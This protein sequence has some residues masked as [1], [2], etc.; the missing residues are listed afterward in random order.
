M[1][2]EGPFSPAAGAN[3]QDSAPVFSPPE[4][5][6]AGAHIASMAQYTEMY[7]RSIKDP[8]GF[9]GDMARENLTWFRDFKEV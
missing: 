4:R 5:V 8:A 6:A 2:E 7:E 9:W 3:E 1:T